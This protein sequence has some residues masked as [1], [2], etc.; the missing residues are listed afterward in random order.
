MYIH[1]CVIMGC[2]L[3]RTGTGGRRGRRSWGNNEMELTGGCFTN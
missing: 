1:A 2:M 3:I